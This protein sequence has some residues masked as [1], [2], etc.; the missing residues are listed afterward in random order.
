M[1]KIPD[2]I[3]SQ[4]SANDQA[5]LENMRREMDTYPHVCQL[6]GTRFP[7]LESVNHAQYGNV[8]RWPLETTDQTVFGFTTEGYRD[9]F[10]A[11]Y[12]AERAD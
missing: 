8:A 11:D 6:P 9:Q 4:L 2:L 12:G 1:F 3:V 5:T 10:A 7:T